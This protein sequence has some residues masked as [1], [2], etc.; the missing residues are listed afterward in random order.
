MWGFY[1]FLTKICFV[2]ALIKLIEKYLEN[3]SLFT[4]DIGTNLTCLRFKKGYSK[5]GYFNGKGA[6]YYC[7]NLIIEI[8]IVAINPTYFLRFWINISVL[9]NRF[10]VY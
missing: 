10:I 1:P 4:Q 3:F 8:D 7:R 6:R 9:D 5:F 2:S